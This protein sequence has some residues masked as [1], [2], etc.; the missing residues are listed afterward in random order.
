MC[1]A[2]LRLWSPD[3]LAC[4]LRPACSLRKTCIF[5]R[6]VGKTDD[7]GLLAAQ[8]ACQGLLTPKTA[9]RRA[10][11]RPRR[12]PDGPPGA[13]DGLPTG[14]LAPKTASPRASWRPR[15]PPD[16]PPGAQDGIPTGFLAPKTASRRAS[17]RPRRPLH[18]PP[19]VCMTTILTKRLSDQLSCR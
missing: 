18:G 3:P 8:T 15:R 6:T 5:A 19:R 1:F 12:P 16:G 10:S 2:I 9:S 11:W 7:S 17:W 13:Q 14:L 4:S